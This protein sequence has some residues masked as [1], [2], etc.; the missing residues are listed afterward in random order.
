[1][2]NSDN[3]DGRK[4]YTTYKSGSGRRSSLDHELA[5]ASAPRPLSAT[6]PGRP[7]TAGAS[8]PIGVEAAPPRYRRYTSQAAN[9]AA[10]SPSPASGARD[11]LRRHRL[12]W[13][14]VPLALVLLLAIAGVLLAV[15]AWPGY[16]TF[17]RAVDASNRQIDSETRA[18]LAPDSGSIWRQGT[19]VLLFGV[20]SKQGE[21][22]RS[23][24]IMLMRFNPAKH[25]V[26]QLSVARDTRVGLPNGTYDKINSAMFWGGPAMAVQ[27][28]KQY[29][30]IDVN[31]VMVVNFKG[32]P[33]LVNAVGGVDI[34]VPKTV[35]TVAGNAGRVV[36][37]PAGINHMDG[38]NAM[39]YVR[40]R[41]ADDDLHRATRQQQFVQALEN[42]LAR[43]SNIPKL[44]EIGKRFMSGVATDLTTAEILQLGYLKWRAKGGKKL[45]L[46]G[47]P[48][49]DGGV[50]YVY[51]PSD[52]EKNRLIQQ[53]LTQ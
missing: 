29:L 11:A 36:T 23:D 17:D 16:A 24:T 4:P 8:R 22:A 15:W 27:T 18:Q 2:R 41:Y 6:A 44:P 45:V 38:K 13:W 51:P 14:A 46:A 35:S 20:D 9:D 34:N 37:F 50:S 39:L 32:F 1:M 31:H 12:R 5:G 25:T 53:F 40:I 42:K 10:I 49:W 52:I 43:P 48:G 3:T 33:R 19:T 28:V 21:P 30:G 7:L 47:T 26:N